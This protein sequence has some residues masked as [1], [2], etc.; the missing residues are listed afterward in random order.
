MGQRSLSYWCI[1]QFT[2]CEAI[3]SCSSP[4][5]VNVINHTVVWFVRYAFTPLGMDDSDFEDTEITL[6]DAFGNAVFIFI[7]SLKFDLFCILFLLFSYYDLLFL[8]LLLSLLINWYTHHNFPVRKLARVFFQE[9]APN[10]QTGKAKTGECKVNAIFLFVKHTHVQPV[11]CP[12]TVGKGETWT[13]R[14]FVLGI[15]TR[16]Q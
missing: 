4:N 2:K 5:T 15:V 16:G 8:L 10:N 12:T 7:W 9:L 6:S 3:F 13:A 1:S 11:K 14:M